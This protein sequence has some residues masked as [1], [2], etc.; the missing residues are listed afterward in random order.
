MDNT[1]K[2]TVENINMPFWSLVG[3]LVKISLAAIPAL[4]ILAIV[5]ALM[6]GILGGVGTILGTIF[7]TILGGN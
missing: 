2:V 5:G 6:L 7:S 3:F 4:F 1:H